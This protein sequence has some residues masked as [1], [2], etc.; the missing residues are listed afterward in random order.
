MFLLLICIINVINKMYSKILTKYIE[1]IQ[2]QNNK[3]L[4][5][6]I[7]ITNVLGRPGGRDR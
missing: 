2:T 6:I 3:F 5:V 7:I 4:K 1:S